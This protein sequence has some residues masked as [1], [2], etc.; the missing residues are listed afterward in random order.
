MVLKILKLPWLTKHLSMSNIFPQYTKFIHLVRHPADVLKSQYA[1]GWDDLLG[2]TLGENPKKKL[3]TD[4][5][6]EMLEIDAWFSKQAPDRVLVVKYEDLISKF[7]PTVRKIADYLGIT[8]T[9]SLM[10]DFRRVR[11]TKFADIPRY[12]GRNMTS[13]EGRSIANR[14]P[15]CRTVMDRFYPDEVHNEL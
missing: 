2:V 3:G 12:S 6:N 13:E 14:L 9:D 5:C 11:E 15:A 1:S 10:S 8:I 4:V 7:D